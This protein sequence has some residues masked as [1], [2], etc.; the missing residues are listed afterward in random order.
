ME[1]ANKSALFLLAT[2]SLWML[3]TT[4]P[5]FQKYFPTVTLAR[6]STHFHPPLTQL[7]NQLVGFLNYLSAYC[8]LHARAG[9]RLSLKDNL[10]FLAAG[11]L[12]TAGHGMHSVC[13]MVEELGENVEKQ[14]VIHVLVDFLHRVV[15]HNMF[16]G[17]MYFLIVLVVR[18]EVDQFRNAS[19][20]KVDDVKVHLSEGTQNGNITQN[21]TQNGN[22]TVSRQVRQLSPSEKKSGGVTMWS[23]LLH[24][25]FPLIL[26]AYF[27][28]FATMT[29]TV[30]ITVLFYLA[31][32]AYTVATLQ[33]M[34]FFSELLK[35]DLL[36][37]GTITKAA[38]A[39]L[40]VLAVRL[41]L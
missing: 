22:I 28:V 41:L 9:G 4:M 5:V 29:G 23:V 35:R 38:C 11:F 10:Y 17:G 3:Q 16:V 34:T 1:G 15:S 18:T 19:N 32:C 8:L 6:H 36:V 12:I 27:S 14:P 31:I 37:L 33:D 30:P 24:W 40:P 13:V 20:K 21:G 25:V 2:F 26:G 7:L 39:G